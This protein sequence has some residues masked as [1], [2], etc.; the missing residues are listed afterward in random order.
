MISRK[1]FHYDVGHDDQGLTVSVTHKP[2][3]RQKTARLGRG[4]K[5]QTVQARLVGDLLTSFVDLRDFVFHV[6]RCEVNGRIGDRYQAEHIPTGRSKS[7]NT[8]DNPGVKHPHEALLDALVEEL[9]HDG[10]LPRQ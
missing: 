6:G 8:V 1:H 7:M 10:I 3:G 2:T 5:V 4:E 9:W